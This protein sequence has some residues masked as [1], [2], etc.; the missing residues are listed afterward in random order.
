MT[1]AELRE[2]ARTTELTI[3]TLLVNHRR[4]DV[5]SWTR[6]STSWR[7]SLAARQAGAGHA[8]ALPSWKPAARLT[9]PP[10]RLCSARSET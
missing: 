3:R 4:S 2:V 7:R 9:G 1:A 8:I 5:T 10:G 6:I